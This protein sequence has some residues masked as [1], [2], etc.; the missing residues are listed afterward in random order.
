MSELILFLLKLVFYPVLGWG[1]VL[2]T[3]MLFRHLRTC[4]NLH[5]SSPCRAKLVTGVVLVIAIWFMC[6]GLPD[7]I[8]IAN[9]PSVIT[10]LCY[11]TALFVGGRDLWQR[12]ESIATWVK[13]QFTIEP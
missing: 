10:F 2:C 9:V 7:T 6:G 1:L 12:R 5:V 3:V 4:N 8:S 13:T 11:V